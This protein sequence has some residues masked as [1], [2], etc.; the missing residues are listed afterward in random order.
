MKEIPMS[1]PVNRMRRLRRTPELR[2]IVREN[3][4]SVDD[5]IVP[6]FVVPGSAV[7]R[8]IDTLPGNY[9]LSVDA[10]VK[11]AREIR[12]LGIKAVLVFGIPREKSDTAAEAYSENGTTQTAIAALK[13][14]VPG[15]IVISDICLCEYT[16]HGHCGIME[17][18]YLQNDKSLEIIAKIAASH[19]AAGAD[20]VAPSAMLD[21]QI[22]TIRSSLDGGGFVNTAIMAYSVK[23]S[24]CLFNPFFKHGTKSVVSYGDKK[25]HQMDY[26]N[27]DEAMR[28]IALDV[29][30]GADIIMVKP[31]LFYLDIVRRAK[32]EYPMPL[33][34]Y[35]VSGEYAMMHAAVEKGIFDLKTILLET[36]ACT[37]RAGADLIITYGAKEAARFLSAGGQ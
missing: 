31:G 27:G 28:E 37:K 35:N 21:G 33:A 12:D 6:L 24:S 7:K 3:A 29:S 23:Y 26:F 18:G 5:F 30:E 34:V 11:E 32:D 16:T 17:D 22:Q 8:E 15:L 2:A 36:L 10:M 19:A 14:Q 1:F 20:M 4:L 25:T 9:H 13:K